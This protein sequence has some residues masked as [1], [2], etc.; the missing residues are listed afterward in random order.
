M[1]GNVLLG[2]RCLIFDEEELAE[3]IGEDTWH[4]LRNNIEPIGT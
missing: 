2:M 4:D 3:G 1:K